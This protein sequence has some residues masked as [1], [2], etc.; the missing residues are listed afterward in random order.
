M[1]KI[2]CFI[3]PDSLA[4]P[5][6]FSSLQQTALWV[7]RDHKV[8]GRTSF[9]T[10]FHP[11]TTSDQLGACSEIPLHQFRCQLWPLVVEPPLYIN[12]TSAEAAPVQFTVN[13]KNV[14]VEFAEDSTASLFVTYN[15]TGQRFVYRDQYTQL[16]FFPISERYRN[17]TFALGPFFGFEWV[18]AKIL[19]MNATCFSQNLGAVFAFQWIWE[20]DVVKPNVDVGGLAIKFS[21]RA[22]STTPPCSRNPTLISLSN[23]RLQLNFRDR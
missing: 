11:T 4:N 14:Q 13:Y 12:G 1:R 2:S 8:C 18:S 22:Y 7:S 16:K 10:I 20:F 23:S 3:L 17:E 19:Q 21:I 5:R 15:K 9:K 6:L